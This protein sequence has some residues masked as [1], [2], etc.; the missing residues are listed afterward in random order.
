MTELA[1]TPITRVSDLFTLVGSRL[2]PTLLFTT[3]ATVSVLGVGAA[4]SASAAAFH[5]LSATLWGLFIVLI[6]IRPAPLRRN[7][8]TIGVIVALVSQLA[9]IAVGLFGAR[10]DGGVAVLASDV[11]L[12]AG[13]AF[14]I[15]SVAVLGRC[16]GVLPDV[17]GLVTRG[18]YRLVRHPLYLG[19]LTAVLGIVLGSRQPLLAGGTWLVCVGLQLARTSY[20]ERNIR[21]EFPQYDEYAARTKRLIPGVL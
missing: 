2:I 10:T 4:P 12:I 19:E 1:A 9:V 13:L 20:E 8:S 11:L 14:A 3:M 16:F 6:N 5:A 7:R 15:C 17:R 18:P 21:A